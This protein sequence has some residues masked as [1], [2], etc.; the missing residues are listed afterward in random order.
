MLFCN[1]T[2]KWTWDASIVSD[3]K[4]SSTAIELVIEKI[5]S[6]DNDA[7]DVL[8][9]AS[10]LGHSFSLGTIKCLV[11]HDKCIED[12]ICTG[13]ITQ[14]KMN[15]S[16]YKFA[17]DQ[18][19]QAA[20]FSITKKNDKK[21]FWSIGQKLLI[22]FPIQELDDNIFVVA[23]LLFHSVSLASDENGRLEIASLLMQAGKKAMPSNALEQSHEC[24]CNGKHLL[25]RECWKNHYDLTL[26]LHN[27][28]AK[29][30]FCVSDYATMN[31]IIEE[32]SQNVASKLHKIQSCSLQIKQCI[33]K[34]RFEKAI[35]SGI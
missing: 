15:N 5:N 7:Q 9:H 14:Q 10:C 20:F 16:I 22:S 32:I 34:R 6:L 11:K 30:A 28:T 19:Q 27:L 31:V 23:R 12:A 35:S 33:G 18:I 21:I 29:S 1:N 2:N 13:V 4:F 26:E 17:H 24:F 3:N 25:G 8:K